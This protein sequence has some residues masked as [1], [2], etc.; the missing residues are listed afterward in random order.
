VTAA[1]IEECAG[2]FKYVVAVNV[3]D[4]HC[5]IETSSLAASVVLSRAGIEPVMQMTTRDRNRIALQSDL[6]GA[7]LLGIKNILCI[8]G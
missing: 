8:S 6:L 1:Q 7:A 2:F 5:G 4:N 3:S